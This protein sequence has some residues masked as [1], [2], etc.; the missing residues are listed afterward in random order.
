MIGN[1]GTVRVP[2]VG[3][4]DATRSRGITGNI[5]IAGTRHGDQAQVGQPIEQVGVNAGRKGRDDLV[6]S[7][8]EHRVGI[9]GLPETDDFEPAVERAVE[10]A[11]RTLIEEQQGGI[12]HVLVPF[13]VAAAIDGVGITIASKPLV[14]EHLV[15]GRLQSML[16][17]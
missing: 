7:R 16:E 2:G 4:G 15:A 12:G 11:L 1:V 6:A 13:A 14:R 10:Q 3:D 5:F 17:R 8:R 9:A